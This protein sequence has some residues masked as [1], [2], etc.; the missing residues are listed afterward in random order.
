MV[1]IVNAVYTG[2]TRGAVHDICGRNRK[3]Q[4]VSNTDAKLV[5]DFIE[6][7]NL[8]FA[9]GVGLRWECPRY[10]RN[11]NCLTMEGLVDKDRSWGSKTIVDLAEIQ[12]PGAYERRG[13]ANC[14]PELC[15]DLFGR[16]L[17]RSDR[18]RVERHL[19]DMYPRA[20]LRRI[21]TIE[22]SAQPELFD[23]FEIKRGGGDDRDSQK[24]AQ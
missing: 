4:N 9:V 7:G 16:L 23:G 24:R 20:H 14:R 21:E 3:S 12:R 6:D 15:T 5:G 19:A 18:R 1:R 8:E 22:S 13:V 2:Y 10:Q 17:G 11:R